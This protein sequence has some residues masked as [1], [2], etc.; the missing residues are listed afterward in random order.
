MRV[1]V[2]LNHGTDRSYLLDFGKDM[3]KEDI[4]DLLERE[5]ATAAELLMVYAALT[6]AVRME[7]HDGEIKKAEQTADYTLSQR[8]YVMERLA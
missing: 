8:G 4:D 1:V 6:S 3:S 7:I 2:H 5:G